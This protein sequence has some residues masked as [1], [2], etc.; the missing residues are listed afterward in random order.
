MAA[1][2]SKR[3]TSSSMVFRPPSLN[4]NSRDSGLILQNYTPKCTLTILTPHT[5]RPLMDILLVRHRIVLGSYI[6]GWV[7]CRR[8]YSALHT[9]NLMLTLLSWDSNMSIPV[10]E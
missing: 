2:E 3:S 7:W 6:K 9:S 4:L 8:M 10:R 5:Q 1:G